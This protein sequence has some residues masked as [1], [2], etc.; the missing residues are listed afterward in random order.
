MTHYK[1][2]KNKV[3]VTFAVQKEH[4]GEKNDGVENEGTEGAIFRWNE[5]SDGNSSNA[6]TTWWSQGSLDSKL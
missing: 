2:E 3:L 5:N 1:I 6:S 4:G